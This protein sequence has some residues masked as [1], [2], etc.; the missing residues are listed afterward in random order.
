MYAIHASTRLPA[1]HILCI[2]RLIITYKNGQ[3]YII[4]R[5]PRNKPLTEE[6]NPCSA[7]QRA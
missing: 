6:K 5:A 3:I 2:Q 4:L 1:V 7:R